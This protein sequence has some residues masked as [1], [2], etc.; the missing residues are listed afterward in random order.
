MSHPGATTAQPSSRPACD[1][2]TRSMDPSAWMPKPN[3]HGGLRRLTI[4]HCGPCGR[5]FDEL[6]GYRDRAV[7][8]N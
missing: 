1:R 2:C 5:V 7:G 8:A 4:H 6:W 3:G